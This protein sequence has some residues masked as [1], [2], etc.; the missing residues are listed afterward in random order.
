LTCGTITPSSITGSGTATLSCSSTVAGNY[1][2]TITG[3]STRF[4][5][6]IP[7]R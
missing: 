2:V 1:T 5:R 4:S 6:S 3:T 7:L